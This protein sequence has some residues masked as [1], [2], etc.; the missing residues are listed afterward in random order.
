MVWVTRSALDAFG[1]LQQKKLPR[2]KGHTFFPTLHTQANRGL[3]LARATLA[4]VFVWNQGQTISW[5]VSEGKYCG[6]IKTRHNILDSE[7]VTYIDDTPPRI[8]HPL[9]SNLL[10]PLSSIIQ[11]IL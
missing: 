10:N 4:E 8:H 11:L 6:E 3:S 7:M 5:S 1:V 9:S 2:S